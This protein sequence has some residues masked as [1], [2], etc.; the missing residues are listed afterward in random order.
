VRVYLQGGLGNQLFQLAAGLAVTERLQVN[1]VLDCS[2]LGNPETALRKFAL[3]PYE[4]PARVHVDLKPSRYSIF[5]NK[6]Q[7]NRLRNMWRNRHLVETEGKFDT[8]FLRV[9]P[10]STLDGYFQSSLYF[11]NV[12]DEILGILES[13]NLGDEKQVV[14]RLNSEPFS[15]V[16]IRR[17]DYTDPLIARVHG[18]AGPGYFKRA[19]EL[20]E[21]DKG[22]T[23]FLYFSDS[24]DLVQHELDLTPE[25]FA[26]N[27]LSEVATLWL[28]SRGNNVVASNSS[29][30]W[31]AGFICTNRVN[32]KVVVPEPWFRDSTPY[33]LVPTSWIRLAK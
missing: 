29:F 31:W 20:L 13:C 33:D 14:K 17:G 1:L 3:G 6:R 22:N 7:V 15:A 10:G 25:D 16:H 32:G 23:R 18:L 12:K 8:K 4:L 2:R 19:V 11:Q 26:P 30:S 24:P 9:R 21:K 27:S 5:M 28:M